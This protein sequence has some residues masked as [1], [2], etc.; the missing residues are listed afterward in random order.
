MN[1]RFRAFSFV[2]RIT[3][4]D[5]SRIAG[6]VSIPATATRFPASLMAE[7]VGQLAAWAAM[8]RLDFAVRPVAGLTREARF[9]RIAQPGDTLQLEAQ[10]AQC[11]ESAVAYSGRALIDGRCALELS[12]CVGPMLP[13]EE[14]DAPAAMRADFDTLLGPGA[15]AGRFAGVPAHR[16]EAAP[17]EQASRRQAALHVP[18]AADAAYFEDHFPR[19]PVFPGTLLL[20]AMASLAVQLGQ[21]AAGPGAVG[22]LRLMSDVKIRSFTVP[23]TTLTLAAERPD[24]DGRDAW[25]QLK[26]L[27]ATRLV[28]TARALVAT[29]EPTP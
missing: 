7:A 4:F 16:L 2:D 14:F 25:M 12:D 26:A 24:D 20:D 22:V 8:S 17:Q 27:N 18:A 1:G 10:L 29:A 3:Q 15:P 6:Q 9:D 28:A 21:D 5:G 23:G 19:R 13:L 11:D